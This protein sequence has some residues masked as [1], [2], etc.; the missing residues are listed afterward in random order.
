MKK[1]YNLENLCCPDCA[2]KIE[3]GI[4]KLDGVESCNVNFLMKKMTIEAAEDDI[5]RITNET[6]SLVKDIEP[7]VEV[8]LR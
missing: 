2:Q 5:E 3:D 4:S 1:K 6:I 7:D 8:V